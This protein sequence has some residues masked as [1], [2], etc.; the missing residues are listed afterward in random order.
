MKKSLFVLVLT[1]ILFAQC[2]KSEE[3]EIGTVT[4]RSAEEIAAMKEYAPAFNL[5]SI[6]GTQISLNELKGKYLFVDIWA[7]WCR[8][9]LQQIPAM[10]ELEQK[11]E[12]K[13]IEF[14][15]ISVDKDADKTK[16]ARMIQAK[17]MGGMQLF[18]GKQT[19]F[20]RD[21]EVS[22][23]PKFLIIGKEGEIINENP[24]RPMDYRTGQVNQELVTILDNLL[25]EK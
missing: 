10:K 14:V 23:I 9:C 1:F 12:G 6:E 4:E 15:S 8:P 16:W 24:P 5:N 18:A 19:T 17:G 7:T 2:K 21:Y 11:Y 13:N 20:S 3:I 22:S 25:K